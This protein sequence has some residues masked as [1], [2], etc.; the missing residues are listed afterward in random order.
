MKGSERKVMEAIFITND[1]WRAQVAERAGVD[2]IMVDLEI[3]GKNERQGH[4][5][6]VISRHTLGDVTYLRSTLSTSSLM[7]RVNPMH[8]GSEEEIQ[9]VIDAGADIVM[10]PMFSYPDEVEKFVVAV[11]GKA[12]TCLLFETGA[13]LANI[14]DVISINGI[15]EA[16][17]GLNDL[18]LSLRLRFM[19]E[20]ISC[21][22]VDYM[23]GA[24]RQK[25][26]KFGIGGVAR[27]GC[28]T[29]PAELVLSE[30]VR[31]GSS[32]VILSRDYGNIFNE[33]SNEQCFE[34]FKQEMCR[35]RLHLDQLGRLSREELLLN[36]EKV[37]A[38]VTGIV[39][40]CVPASRP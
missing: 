2:R 17:I 15:D 38:A 33:C 29:L 5:N 39:A 6:T 36:S 4:L 37:K 14:H 40:T 13:A 23:A 22:L 10:L 31:L 21:G 3:L 8:G 19:F 30:H 26:L 24:F 20:L 28:G 25:G 11:G 12:R 16:H 1:P 32:R 27:L 34:V 9:A 7:V 35:F 18:H